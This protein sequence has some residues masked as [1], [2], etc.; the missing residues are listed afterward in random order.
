[1]K[2]VFADT[3]YW[4]AVTRPDDQWSHAAHAAK[5]A[6]G[7]A[8][9][10]TTDEVLVEFLAAM[11][12]TPQRRI[13]ALQMV[14]AIIAS[15]SVKILPQSRDSFIKGLQLYA[16]RLDKQYSLTDCISMNAMRSEGATEVLTNDC[17]FSQ[18]G[19]TVL[20]R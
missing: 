18:E 2:L 19:F 12:S 10:L 16:R 7:D 8:L 15:R 17:H 3:L 5:A 11:S 9:I 13:Q 1:M 6:L 20:I 14:Q 4:V